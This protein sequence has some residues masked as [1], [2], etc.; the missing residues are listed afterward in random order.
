LVWPYAYHDIFYYTLWPY[1]YDDP[2]WYH[3]YGA[4]YD[5]IFTPYAYD[6]VPYTGTRQQ[7]ARRS[8]PSD[9]AIRDEVT[10]SLSQMC[11]SDT[12]DVAGWPVDRIQQALA[13]DAQKRMLLDQLANASIKAG[14]AIR[15]AC[16]TEVALTPTGRLENMEKRIAGMI[17]AVDTVRA[18]LE[19]FYNSLSDEQKARFNAMGPPGDPR[20]AA[21]DARNG[22]PSGLAACGPH[23]PGVTA[24]PTAEIERAV[25]PTE[26]QRTSLNELADAAAK[27][28]DTLKAACPTTMPQTPPGRLDAVAKRLDAL[29][30]AVKDVRAALGNFYGSLYDEQKAR[31][32]AIGRQRPART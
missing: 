21:R 10:G 18:P 15:A 6:V 20:A 31:F 22:R 19:N 29:L 26:A 1:W 5:G 24:W 12:R 28:S 2:F 14:E 13:P 3:G 11:T 27:A 23:A 16:P 30:A 25:H 32:N 9:D 8:G 4:I 7:V 17:Q